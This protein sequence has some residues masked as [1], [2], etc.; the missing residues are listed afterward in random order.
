VS[1][2]QLEEGGHKIIMNVGFLKIWD[3]HTHAV[4]KVKR[5][6]NRLYVIWLDIDWPVCLAAQGDGPAWRWLT[7]FGHLDFCGLRHLATGEMVKGLPRIDHVDQVCD[8]YRADKQHR[9][10]F[11]G[12]A[13]CHATNMLELMH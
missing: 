8:S 10:S 11:L 4:A 7:R 5:A 2:S 9:L 6:V 13:K 3:H 1:L 12:V